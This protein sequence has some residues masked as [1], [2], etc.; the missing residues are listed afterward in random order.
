[1]LA[2][3]TYSR[4]LIVDNISQFSLYHILCKNSKNSGLLPTVQ[5]QHSNSKP[6]RTCYLYS[7]RKSNIVLSV[8][9]LKA[10]TR[11][12]SFKLDFCEQEDVNEGSE[13][14]TEIVLRL[15]HCESKSVVLSPKQKAHMLIHSPTVAFL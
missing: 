15:S 9:L 8:E 6:V 14:G 4:V 1:M 13:G 5:L 12:Q 7:V 3:L 11:E 2:N 10:K